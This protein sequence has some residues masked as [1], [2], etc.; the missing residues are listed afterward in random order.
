M[1]TVRD[2]ID[3][4][5][6]AERFSEDIGL[7]F[8]SHGRVMKHRGRIPEAHW[9]RIVEAAKARGIPDLTLDMLAAAHSSQPEAR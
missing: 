4:W 7:R 9:P 6:S 2:I 1:T 3:L 8:P 5:P